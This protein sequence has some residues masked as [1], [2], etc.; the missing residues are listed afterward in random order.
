MCVFF[1]GSN[2]QVTLWA[3]EKLNKIKQLLFEYMLKNSI[4]DRSIPFCQKPRAILCCLWCLSK[5]WTW[6]NNCQ[7][8]RNFVVFFFFIH[9][10]SSKSANKNRRTS[11]YKILVMLKVCM[12]KWRESNQLRLLSRVSSWGSLWAMNAWRLG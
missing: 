4:D 6:K 9:S 11:C 5:W 2:L 1:T 7:E 3:I 12:N 10:I 8:N